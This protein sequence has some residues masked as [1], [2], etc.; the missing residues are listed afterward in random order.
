MSTETLDNTEASIVTSLS[1]LSRVVASM[2]P[3]VEKPHKSKVSHG[4][5]FEG[6][7]FTSNYV[8]STTGA[9]AAV[10]FSAG[11]GWSHQGGRVLLDAAQLSTALTQLTKLVKSASPYS[12]R[13]DIEYYTGK[14]EV[15]LTT[16]G[17]MFIVTSGEFSCSGRTIR[18]VGYP[19]DALETY[20][21]APK[22]DAFFQ[23]TTHWLGDMFIKVGES[24][25]AY[26]MDDKRGRSF[27]L[28]CVQNASAARMEYSDPEGRLLVL[29][30]PCRW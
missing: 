10:W 3:H 1:L 28:T 25:N 27:A 8:A 2:M 22:T 19:T 29:A 4:R 6:V 30:M 24:F 12:R 7:L 9:S 15:T 23:G 16:N 18:G 17:S 14:S 21:T 20:F 11:E 13:A 26:T 5:R